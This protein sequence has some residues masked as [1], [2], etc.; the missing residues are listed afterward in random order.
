MQKAADTV[1]NIPAFE[2]TAKDLIVERVQPLTTELHC[3]VTVNDRE[4]VSE[5]RAP[6]QLVNRRVQKERV[7]ESECSSETHGRISRHIRGSGVTRPQLAR[8]REVGLVDSVGRERAEK[9]DVE[10]VDLRWAFN[11]IGRVSVG[12]N[13]ERLISVLRIV[14]VVRER[15]FVLRVEVPVD[16][17]QESLVV[18]LMTDRL[19]LVLISGRL[20]EIDEGQSLTIGAAVD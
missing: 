20:D 11:A 5:V 3:M 15:Q 14:E 8:V 6:K 10:V 12:R 1:E 9:I 2:E 7:A 17:T 4:V 18:D 19:S 16:L 13:V